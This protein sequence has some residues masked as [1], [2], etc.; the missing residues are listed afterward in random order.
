[1]SL[2]AQAQLESVVPHL[3]KADNAGSMERSSMGVEEKA[4]QGLR[5][6]CEGP[7]ESRSCQA[8]K[9]VEAPKIGSLGGGSVGFYKAQDE[10]PQFQITEAQQD[11]SSDGYGEIL[12]KSSGERGR[13][14]V[15]FDAA[16]YTEFE[17]TSYSEIY[18]IHPREFVF[19]RD[20]FMLPAIGFGDVGSA[21]KCQTEV[22][23][24][25]DSESDEDEFEDDWDVEYL[26]RSLV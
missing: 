10:L 7:V 25:N 26:I 16:E 1:M 5:T 19:D 8:Q 11:G 15:Q 2:L 4:T 6:P 3:R 23:E 14:R 20:S 9:S 22:S 17:I 13:K 21:A 24:E 18:G 12:L